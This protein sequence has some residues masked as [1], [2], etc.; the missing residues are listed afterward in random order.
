[1]AKAK[2][3]KVTFYCREYLFKK[4]RAKYE[5]ISQQLDS[6]IEKDIKQ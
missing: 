4:F 1:M 2:I 5:N 6:M 3:K